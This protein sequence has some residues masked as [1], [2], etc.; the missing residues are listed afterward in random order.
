MDR[1]ELRSR[2]LWG[3]VAVLIIG[4]FVIRA[5]RNKGSLKENQNYTVGICL[6]KYKGIKQP[7]PSVEFEY[8]ISNKRYTQTQG[9]DPKL[10]HAVI[11]QKYLVIYSPN[12]PS[13][14]RILLSE[15]LADSIHAPFGGWE[16]APFG[17]KDSLDVQW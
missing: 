10:Y 11:G 14:S 13:N 9:F 6:D 4:F 2:I 17:L 5:A 15:P 1:K 16:N 3:I 8:Y 7:I 12:N